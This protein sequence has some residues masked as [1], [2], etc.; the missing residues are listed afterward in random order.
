MAARNSTT[1]SLRQQF[2]KENNCWKGM[3]ARCYNRS[4]ISYRYYGAKGI[5]VCEPWRESFAAFLADVSPAPSPRHCLEREKND[6]GYEPG[7]VRWATPHEQQRNTSKCRWLTHGGVTLCLTDWALRLGTA[8]AT[9]TCRLARGWS[10]ERALTTP[11]NRSMAPKRRPKRSAK[12]Q[13]KTLSKVALL[14]HVLT[15]VL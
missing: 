2:P 13:D 14:Q 11:P 7:N 4:S 8:N 15:D 9:I 12:P 10:V 3:L 1:P 5:T 6:V